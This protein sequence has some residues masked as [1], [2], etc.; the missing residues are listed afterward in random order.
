MKKLFVFSFV[1][2]FFSLLYGETLY[3][4]AEGKKIELT[5]DFSSY[6][7]IRTSLTKANFVLPKGVKTLKT[8]KNIS[9]VELS[10]KTAAVSL[11]KNGV[12]FPA[13]IKNGTKVNVSGM[14]FVKIPGQ[15]SGKNAEKWCKSHG[16][17]LIKQ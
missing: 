2:L 3:Y 5:E 8:Y 10:D 9:I 13:Y 4:Y 15:P 6:S 14:L 7:F 17:T 16:M 1:M 12:L 11:K